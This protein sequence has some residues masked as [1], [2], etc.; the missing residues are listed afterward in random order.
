MNVNVEEHAVLIQAALTGLIATGTALWG[1]FGWLVFAWI[2]A[3]LLD[4]VTGTAAAAKNQIWDSAKLREG[5]WHKGGMILVV[6]ASLLT[7]GVITLI[8]Q[9]GIIPVPVNHS[10]YLTAIVL[11][12]YTVGELG[13]VLE[14]ATKITDKIPMWLI[15]WLKITTDKI[16][17]IGEGI[18]DEAGGENE[19]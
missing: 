10:I 19:H 7:D 9:S 18:A 11:S 5:L 1:W 6:L 17:G 13:S 4:L 15:R 16:N 12:A 8:L 14:N 2:G 3:M